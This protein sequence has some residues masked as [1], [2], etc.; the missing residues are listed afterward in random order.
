MPWGEIDS[1]QLGGTTRL[2]GRFRDLDD[3]N[4][5]PIARL[6]GAGGRVVRLEEIAEVRRDLER[7]KTRAF[8]SYD[9]G[10][11]KRSTDISLT[12]VSGADT[13]KA[14][15]NAK[16]ELIAARAESNWPHGL[17]YRITNDQADKIWE[18]LIRVFDNGYWDAKRARAIRR[19]RWIGSHFGCPDALGS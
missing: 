13:L 2:Y 11:F 4:K 8:L 3:L 19:P 1:D 12:K 7:E 15:E 16:A 9:G 17:V 18:S 5:L 14:I 10:E 6:D